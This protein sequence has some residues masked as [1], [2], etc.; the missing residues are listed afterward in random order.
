MMEWLIGDDCRVNRAIA[1]LINSNNEVVP[2][3]SG[4][5]TAPLS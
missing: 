5:L 2:L 3:G 4:L 1:R